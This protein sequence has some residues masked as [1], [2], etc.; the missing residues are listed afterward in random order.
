[1]HLDSVTLHG[2]VAS[3]K[4]WGSEVLNYLSTRDLGFKWFFVK[5]SGELNQIVKNYKIEII[6][7]VHWNW[8]VPTLIT[9]RIKCLCLHMTDLPYGRGGSPLQN[10]IMRGHTTTKLTIFQMT[11]ELDAGP[12]YIQKNMPLHGSAHDIYLR[13]VEISKFMFEEILVKDLSP[14]PQSGS[15]T[16]FGRR[17]PFES[18]WNKFEFVGTRWGRS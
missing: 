12:I 18:F 10:L 17:K 6:F 5:D 1:M 13:M 9:S 3:C 16:I 8:F 4:P 15:P 14:L 2:I 11:N 7:F